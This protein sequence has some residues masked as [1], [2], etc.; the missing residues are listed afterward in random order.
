[1]RWRKSEIIGIAYSRNVLVSTWVNINVL[2][3]DANFPLF[4]GCPVL[5]YCRLSFQ[6]NIGVFRQ[7]MD[8]WEFFVSGVAFWVYR[9]RIA[10]ELESTFISVVEI[11]HGFS[12]HSDLHVSRVG[13]KLFTEVDSLECKGTTGMLFLRKTKNIGSQTNLR[14]AFLLAVSCERLRCFPR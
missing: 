7:K 9:D 14:L 13:M 11:P 1:M 10:Q 6:A 2:R 3:E 5:E 4:T 8:V 12:R